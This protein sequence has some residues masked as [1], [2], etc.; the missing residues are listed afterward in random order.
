MSGPL[1]VLLVGEDPLARAGLAGTLSEHP[2]CE[3][4]RSGA[5]LHV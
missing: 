2:T 1:R 4:T 3:G 5:A